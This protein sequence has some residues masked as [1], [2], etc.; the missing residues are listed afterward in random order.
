LGQAIDPC[1]APQLFER[2]G[3]IQQACPIEAPIGIP[4]KPETNVKVVELTGDPRI[5]HDVD[6]A[7]VAE[8]MVKLRPGR[9]FVDAVKVDE[10][11]LAHI[12]GQCLNVVKIHVLVAV[13]RAYPHD[14]SLISHDVD[15]A[16]LLEE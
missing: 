4:I 15:Q 6:G 8:E 10:E 9:K 2:Q 13:I 11:E 12:F 3:G 5:T 14:V 16:E 7:T 1:T